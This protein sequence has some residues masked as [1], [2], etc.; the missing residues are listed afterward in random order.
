MKVIGIVGGT[1]AGK[2]TALRE[3]EAMNVEILDCDT[4]YHQLLQTSTELEKRL[5]ARFGEV[6]DADGLNRKKLGNLVFQNPKAL[7]DLN[8]ITFGIITEEVRRRVQQAQVQGKAGA[9][10]DAVALLES[11]LKN[12]CEAI[13]AVTAPAEIRIR[14]IMDREGISQ[15]YARN[16]VAAQHDEKWFRE[17]CGYVLENDGTVKEFQE[18]CRKLFSCLMSNE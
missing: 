7:A 10:I 9:A 3:L 11:D 5:T 16:R 15:E 2:T 12:D 13:V 18:K 6:F 1:G 4:I 8:A 17:R 14:R